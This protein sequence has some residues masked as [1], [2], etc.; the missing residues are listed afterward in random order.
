MRTSSTNIILLAIAISNLIY[1]VYPIIEWL[2]MEYDS[3]KT[4]QG[5][6]QWIFDLMYYDP[7]L[8][9]VS[10]LV[11]SIHFVVLLQ[12]SM[13]TSSTNIMLLAI[14]I[15]NLAYMAYPVINSLK[16][17]YDDTKPCKLPDPYAY[18]FFKWIYFSVQD[19]VRRCDAF[20]GLAMASIRTFVLK[21]PMKS[22]T[23]TSSSFGWKTCL[24]LFLLSSIISFAYLLRTEVA[25]DNWSSEE[26]ECYERFPNETSGKV[27]AV[28]PS[29]LSQWNLYMFSR[30]QMALDG[31][32]SKVR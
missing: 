15:Y 29:K 30:V 20:L 12:K 3:T 21:F 19:D 32:F 14:A 13:R 8:S 6:R 11:N 22:N 27:Y 24:I 9:A 26:W 16:G 4:W 17:M 10:F 25:R 31:T 5:L 7:H 28:V 18:V 23:A 1:M 2:K